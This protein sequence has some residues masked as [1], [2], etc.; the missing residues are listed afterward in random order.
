[1]ENFISKEDL[2]VAIGGIFAKME[3]GNIS[4][5]EM[6][7]LVDFTS[8][9]H[10][11]SVIL[12]YKAIEK[13]VLGQ[14]DFSSLNEEEIINEAPQFENQESIEETID[15]V[16]EKEEETL[17][18]EAIINDEPSNEEEITFEQKE[19][20]P[21]SFGFNLFDFEEKKEEEQN[22]AQEEMINNV[23]FSESEDVVETI[24]SSITNDYF[25][26]PK[27]I[28]TEN[29]FES[30]QEES[31]QTQETVV[32]E[33]NENEIGEPSA[34]SYSELSAFINK[35]NQVEAITATQFGLVKID[36]LIGSF[37]LNERLQYINELFDG[38]SENFSDAVKVLDNQSTIESAKTKTAELA[39]INNWDIESDTIVEFMQKVVRRYA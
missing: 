24:P 21:I 2:L 25:N 1:M 29:S 19:E 17:N 22:I 26:T 32:E 34:F 38:S 36:S 8:E 33:I 27:D 15:T 6:N 39:L 30:K 11:R 23:A 7:D 18:E 10:Q 9:L 28:V 14:E 20:E 4:L 5:V 37:G 16:V 12:R 31:V 3:N 13:E 35:F